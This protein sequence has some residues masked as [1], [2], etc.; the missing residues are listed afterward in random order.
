VK[1]K[2]IIAALALALS[3]SLAI[4]PAVARQTAEKAAS[5]LSEDARI[6]SAPGV[7]LAATLRVPAGKGPHPVLIIQSG[8]GP[9]KRG[10]YVP[11]EHR[12]NDIGIATIE[13][14][15]RGVGQ[16]TGRL[17]D[18]M[19]DMEADITA[20]IA[21]LR[22]RPD[23]DGSRI[24][25]LGHSQGA[26]AVP[27][28]A[29]RDGHIAAIVFLAGPVGQRG[30]MFLEGMRRQLV[31]GG[32]APDLADRVTVATGRWMEERSQGEHANEILQARNTVVAEF[33]HAGFSQEDAESATKVLDTPQVLSMYQV[34]PGTALA[35]L[36]IPVLAIFG[37]R[38][39]II[40]PQSDAAA[41][42]MA[43]NPKALVLE[44]P[45]ANHGFGHRPLDAPARESP[46]GGPWL[47][48]LPKALITDWLKEWLIDPPQVDRWEVK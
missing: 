1:P 15:K 38:D 42:A 35:H 3:V 41:A 12:L 48:L 23:I 34:G 27:I 40:G 36:Q 11:L 44:I 2:A 19:Q 39:E 10:G 26:A 32:R 30:T 22:K 46:G 28:V 13:F 20:T 16:S 31:E 7:V 5:E 25:L 18:T 9:S 43:E 8:S 6:Q 33:M 17:T 47:S 21:W 24:A 45:G 29:D 14:D 4:T 37:A